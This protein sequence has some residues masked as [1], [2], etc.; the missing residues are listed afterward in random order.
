MHNGST[1]PQNNARQCYLQVES[2][3]C[4][5][6][7]FEGNL[8]HFHTWTWKILRVWTIWFGFFRQ[9]SIAFICISTI[10]GSKRK[11]ANGSATRTDSRMHSGSKCS[12][13]FTDMFLDSL[14]HWYS[15]DFT[16][17]AGW[18]ISP[19][20]PERMF[21]AFALLDATTTDHLHNISGLECMC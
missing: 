13:L 12:E 7:R 9:L 3:T 21:R 2:P 15:G 5:F 18:K 16:R 10:V 19:R 1:E 4:H 14:T 20:I 6:N 8:S 17:G 11:A